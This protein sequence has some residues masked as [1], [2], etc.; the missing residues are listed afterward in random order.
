MCGELYPQL[1]STKL[2]IYHFSATPSVNQILQLTDKDMQGD[3]EIRRTDVR[4]TDGSIRSPAQYFE[5]VIIPN[6]VAP[7]RNS[8]TG[9]LLH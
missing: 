3:Y 5:A 8:P 2:F 1:L 7:L 4:K 9:A 6:S